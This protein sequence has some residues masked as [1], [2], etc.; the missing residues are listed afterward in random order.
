MNQIQNRYK[1]VRCLGKGKT[2]FVFEASRVDNPSI[3]VAIKEYKSIKIEQ[4]NQNHPLFMIFQKE[5]YF[6]QAI[7]NLINQGKSTQDFQHINRIVEILKLGNETSV[8]FLLVL[9]FAKNGNLTDFLCENPWLPEQI[10]SAYILQ[11]TKAV[12]ILHDL[13]VAHMDIKP[14]N[15][16]LDERFILKLSDFGLVEFNPESNDIQG[17][18]G[19]M[20]PEVQIGEKYLPKKA[21]I[22][23]LGCSFIGIRSGVNPF[24]DGHLDMNNPIYLDLLKQPKQFWTYFEQFVE[25][26][27]KVKITIEEEFKDLIERMLTNIPD[28]RPTI[29][30][31]LQHPYLNKQHV[32]EQQMIDYMKS[33][34]LERNIYQLNSNAS[35]YGQEV[36]TK[37]GVTEIEQIGL[38]QFRFR[39]LQ[40][41]KNFRKTVTK[42]FNSIIA[43]SFEMTF[44]TNISQEY[45]E[46]HM[47]QL[48][49]NMDNSC[50]LG[51]IMDQ[52][53]DVITINIIGMEGTIQMQ[54]KLKKQI[55]DQLKAKIQK[56]DQQ[57][58]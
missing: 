30:Q 4:A 18:K 42:F 10:A 56:Q 23:S 51:V 25:Q 52:E 2:S 48:I 14:E 17:T 29:D 19:Y 47:N 28:K 26:E 24:G 35:T 40:N 45:E 13:N 34:F 50:K 33:Q 58:V 31:V 22:F 46:R 12:K 37:L 6:L 43:E 7:E 5:A 16:L 3:Q 57:K 38:N 8:S 27:N 41:D 9:E 21:D 15:M 11:I 39:N 49:R 1:L 36:Y 20:A 55:R 53:P 44:E 54:N 32:S